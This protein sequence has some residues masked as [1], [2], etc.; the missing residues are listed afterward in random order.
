[1]TYPLWSEEVVVQSP[2]SLPGVVTPVSSAHQVLN[3]QPDVD[4]ADAVVRG[5]VSLENQTVL[6]ALGKGLTDQSK[7]E[8]NNS[9]KSKTHSQGHSLHKIHIKEFL[10]M[11][12]KRDYRIHLEVDPTEPW[13]FS[14]GKNT[15]CQ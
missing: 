10:A 4:E 6:T 7:E 1:M 14:L 15:Q 5:Q 11:K 8:G 12:E 2:E 3:D 9:T 13:I